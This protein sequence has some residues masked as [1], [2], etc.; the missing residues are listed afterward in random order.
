MKRARLTLWTA[1]VAVLVLTGCGNG[2]ENSEAAQA[3]SDIRAELV[4]ALDA[5]EVARAEGYE[6]LVELWDLE[7]AFESRIPG[8]RMY[9]PSE[10]VAGPPDSMRDRFARE[11]EAE[12]EELAGVADDGLNFHG[13]ILRGSIER[14]IGR[15]EVWQRNLDR[16]RADATEREE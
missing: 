15:N 6:I 16:A 5:L 14:R 9:Y 11:I 2:S 8:A 7:Q 13:Q 12:R 10:T 3:P 4:A 1:A